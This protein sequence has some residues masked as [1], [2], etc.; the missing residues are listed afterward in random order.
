MV[1]TDEKFASNTVTAA[2][3]PDGITDE[4]LLNLLRDEYDIVAAE[5]RGR[6]AGKVF[7]I[8]HMGYVN[9]PMIIATLGCIETVFSTC[10]IPHGKGGIMAALDSLANVDAVQA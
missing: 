9:A 8:G 3:L 7:R 5:G 2:W 6:L 4:A 10:G 1:A